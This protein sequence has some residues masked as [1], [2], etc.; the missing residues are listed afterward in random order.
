M[1]RTIR[2]TLLA[3]ALAIGGGLGFGPSLARAYDDG[4][5]GYDRGYGAGYGGYDRGYGVGYGGY[6][7][8]YDTR[9]DDYD[10]DYGAGYGGY[11]GAGYGYGGYS[12]RGYGPAPSHRDC[13][14]PPPPPPVCGGPAYTALPRSS[15]IDSYRYSEYRREERTTLLGSSPYS[16]W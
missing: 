11:R 7:R 9:Y 1:R 4:Y 10:R 6:D 15:G 16:P 2:A 5:G 13:V 12:G 3:G 14:P 8:G